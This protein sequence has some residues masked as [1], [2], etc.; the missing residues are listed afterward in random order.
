MNKEKHM[1][2]AGEFTK[3][4]HAYIH[5]EVKEG[6][7]KIAVG[8]E[9]KAIIFGIFRVMSRLCKLSGIP[10]PVLIDI[11]NDFYK[12]EEEEG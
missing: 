2:K 9:T 12:F 7:T 1:K 5:C 6:D 10:F 11:L 3:D 4:K 8:G